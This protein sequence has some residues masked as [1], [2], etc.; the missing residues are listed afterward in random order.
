MLI[1]RMNFQ[2]NFRRNFLT[3]VT[4]FGIFLVIH[5]F[6]LRMQKRIL[7]LVTLLVHKS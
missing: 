3:M 4:I 6:K 2:Y 5:V 1:E 7:L